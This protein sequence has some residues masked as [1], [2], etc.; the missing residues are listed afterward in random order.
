[1]VLINFSSLLCISS[2]EKEDGGEEMAILD[3]SD[4]VSD[5]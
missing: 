3:D 2:E 1:M 5:L 4:C